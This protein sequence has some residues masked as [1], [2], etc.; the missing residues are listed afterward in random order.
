[1]ETQAQTLARVKKLSETVPPSEQAYNAAIA[2][3]LAALIVRLKKTEGAWTRRKISEM[4]SVLTKELGISTKAFEKAFRGDMDKIIWDDYMHLISYGDEGLYTM[5]KEGLQNILD[6]KEIFFHTEKADGTENDSLMKVAKGFTYPE[7]RAIERSYSIITSGYVQG[8]N[9]NII[10]RQI[11]DLDKTTKSYVRTFTRT[12]FADAQNRVQM[13]YLEDNQ[14]LF[15]FF[16]F[17]AKLDTRTTIFCR[18]ADETKWEFLEDVPEKYY[19][20]CHPNC[21]SIIVGSVEGE[22]KDP[23]D[24]YT[25]VYKTREVKR[26]KNKDG[27]YQDCPKPSELDPP[28]VLS[29]FISNIKKVTGLKTI[30]RWTYSERVKI[31]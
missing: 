28:L 24:G 31:R 8:I 4:I 14:H 22:A 12:M 6:F 18:D 21:R 30:C 26:K 1:M 27:T 25:T 5:D 10:Y 11:K 9:P 15:G 2:R 7:Q 23:N 20:P 16:E 13:Q 17:V 29:S 19:P 3:A